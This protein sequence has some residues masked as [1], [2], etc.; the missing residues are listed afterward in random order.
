MYSLGGHT[1]DNGMRW[2]IFGDDT[3]S[4]YNGI[5]SYGNAAEDRGARTDGGTTFHQRRNASP[6]GIGLQ[7]TIDG[8]AGIFVVDE[9]DVMSNEH[10]IL[11]RHAFADKSMAGNFDMPTNFRPLLD[12]DEGADLRII[13]DFTPVEINEVIDGHLLA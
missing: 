3:A 1:G 4:T 10:V 12:L 11:D 5:F 6:I 2:H 13:T 9:R 7:P 8:G